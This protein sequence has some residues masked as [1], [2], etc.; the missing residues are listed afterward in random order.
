DCSAESGFLVGLFSTIDAMLDRPMATIIDPLP[1]SE[2]T[3]QALNSKRGDLG[4]LLQHVIY[5][6]QGQWDEIS[7]EQVTLEQ[8]SDV[9]ID[10]AEWAL[11]TKQAI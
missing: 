11:K 3:K 6:E 10:A 9:Y 7:N 8:F 5:Y 4:S 2:A 1:L